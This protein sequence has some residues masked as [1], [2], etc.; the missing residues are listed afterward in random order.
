MIRIRKLFVR[1]KTNY[2]IYIENFYQQFEPIN[3]QDDLDKLVFFKY[4]YSL[5]TQHC[6]ESKLY[7]KLRTFPLF[8]RVL[9]S[10][11]ADRFS[12]GVPEF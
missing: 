10:K 2:I 9:Q 8:Y 1:I 3:K 4:N 12:T 6:M 11:I 5:V 7:P